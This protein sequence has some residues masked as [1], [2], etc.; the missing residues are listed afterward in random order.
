MNEEQKYLFD[1]FGYIVI[2]NVLTMT[3]I[4]RLRDTIAGPTEQFPPVPQ[5]EDHSTGIRY[6]EISWI[7]RQSIRCWN[8]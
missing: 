3:D 6:G 5:D 4:E 7:T 1:V 2:P 8:L